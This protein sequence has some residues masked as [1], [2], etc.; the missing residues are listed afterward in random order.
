M[1]GGRVH[2]GD[3]GSEEAIGNGRNELESKRG[4]CARQ[5]GQNTFQSPQERLL[6]NGWRS[7]NRK[8]G[9]P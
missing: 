5:E 4:L 3:R 1:A 8:D 6:S 2:V 7:E 9:E